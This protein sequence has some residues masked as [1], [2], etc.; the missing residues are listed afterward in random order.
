M[1]D[2][3]YSFHEKEKDDKIDNDA[4]ALSEK[5]INQILDAISSFKN[6]TNSDQ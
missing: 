6:T 1:N 2:Y 3:L 4:A 5:I